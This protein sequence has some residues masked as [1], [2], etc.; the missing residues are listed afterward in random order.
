MQSSYQQQIDKDVTC[1]HNKKHATPVK[2]PAAQRVLALMDSNED[3]DGRF[4]E[5]V[6][7][8]SG[9]MGISTSQIEKELA[10]FI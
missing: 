7:Q 9:E 2:S 3:G 8:V 6:K 10:H 5:F 4:G 1:A